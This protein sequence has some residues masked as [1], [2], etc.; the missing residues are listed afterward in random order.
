MICFI[1]KYLRVNDWYDSKV[2]FLLCYLLCS[3]FLCPKID[4]VSFVLIFSVSFLFVF[5]FLA[6]G[7]LVNDYCD[8]ESDKKVGKDK[9]I[10]T[11]SERAIRISF[12]LVIVGAAFPIWIYSG[13]SWFMLGTEILT[14]LS[15]MSYSME[16]FRFKEKGVWGLLISSSAQRCMPL[17]VICQTMPI[18][19]GLLILFLILSFIIGLRYIFIHQVLDLE[20]D[21]KSGVKTFVDKYYGIASIGVYLCFLLEIAGTIGLFFILQQ[22]MLW[23]MIP[24]CTLLELLQCRAVRECMRQSVFL[25]F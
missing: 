15:G 21:R 3:Y 2:P 1:G 6:F 19:K 14:F 16:P 5:L 22:K 20:N 8:R 9:V 12:V 23:Y 25:T 7:Y 10:F 17:L 4:T 18:N 13:F 24:L 11:M